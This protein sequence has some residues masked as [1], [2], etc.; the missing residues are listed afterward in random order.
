M[1]DVEQNCPSSLKRESWRCE[2]AQKQYRFFGADVQIGV[3][4]SSVFTGRLT[5]IDIVVQDVASEGLQVPA[6]QAQERPLGVGP[7][8]HFLEDVAQNLGR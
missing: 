5:D 7:G 1:R 3:S 2:G 6:D 4:A 8:S